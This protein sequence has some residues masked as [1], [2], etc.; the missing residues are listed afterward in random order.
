MKDVSG[1]TTLER[2]VQSNR[3]KLGKIRKVV[4][5]WNRT[6]PFRSKEGTVARSG[7]A[8]CWR[9]GRRRASKMGCNQR[10]VH[11]CCGN[12]VFARAGNWTR[13]EDTNA[14]RGLRVGYPFF[15]H[16]CRPRHLE[17][18]ISTT[19]TKKLLTKQDEKDYKLQDDK[20]ALCLFPFSINFVVFFFCVSWHIIW[21]YPMDSRFF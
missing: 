8:H 2:S 16:W 12:G 14:V 6:V 9:W 21:F 4:V 20:F 18:K 7:G 11:N 3:L 5:A 10:W 17:W 1:F 13:R 19:R 15:T